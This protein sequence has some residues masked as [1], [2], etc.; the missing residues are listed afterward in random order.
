MGDGGRGGAGQ[1]DHPAASHVA[2]SAGPDQA[3][4]KPGITGQRVQHRSRSSGLWRARSRGARVVAAAPRRAWRRAHT[5]QRRGDWL[6][7]RLPR[8]RQY[9][10]R[11]LQPDKVEIPLTTAVYRFVGAPLRRRARR[12]PAPTAG[13][14]SMTSC[15]TLV[16]VCGAKKARGVARH[17]TAL[18]LAQILMSA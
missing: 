12:E 16:V 6:V 11:D 14:G 1:E 15:V 13:V 18:D 3:S 5:D 17:H 2:I 4:V 9:S 10:T 7:D 8:S